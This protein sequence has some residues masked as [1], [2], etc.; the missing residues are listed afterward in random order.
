MSE[1]TVGP[2]S[3]ATGSLVPLPHA[4]PGL[5]DQRRTIPPG[6]RSPASRGSGNDPTGPRSGGLDPAAASMARPGASRPPRE[7][8]G[9]SLDWWPISRRSRRPARIGRI[10]GE[11]FRRDRAEPK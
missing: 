9:D 5:Y 11:G 2:E 7:V 1:A 3:V 8:F 6:S 4:G 10:F